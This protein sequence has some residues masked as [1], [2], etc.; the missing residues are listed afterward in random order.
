MDY[1][2]QQQQVE[3]DF[4][5]KKKK[6][7]ENAPNSD[8]QEVDNRSGMTVDAITSEKK[9]TAEIDYSAFSAYCEYYI[10]ELSN[11]HGPTIDLLSGFVKTVKEED[12]ATL[13]RLVMV[14]SHFHENTHFRGV[15][16]FD[17]IYTLV[18][19]E[20]GGVFLLDHHYKELVKNVSN[21]IETVAINQV[22]EALL[23]DRQVKL[24]IEI[25]KRYPLKDIYDWFA[26]KPG[27][28]PTTKLLNLSKEVWECIK[29]DTYKIK[30][31]SY[32]GFKIFDLFDSAK[33]HLV[34]LMTTMI[35]MGVVEVQQC[36]S[37]VIKSKDDVFKHLLEMHKCKNDLQMALVAI[38][39]MSREELVILLKSAQTLCRFNAERQLRH[40]QQQQTSAPFPNVQTSLPLSST[41]TTSTENQS[42]KDVD[43]L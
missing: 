12:G 6:Q 35:L 28:D 11:G 5:A 16:L 31:K 27:A 43:M 19:L 36:V 10:H 39:W 26:Y 13:L 20:K 30:D 1:E 2:N 23:V 8:K 9:P 38:L 18:G 24:R 14:F 34:S 41:I 4:V 15:E 37:D 25:G 42:N 21:V 22:V 32:P 3:D 29:A 33:I 7:L 40:E 17:S